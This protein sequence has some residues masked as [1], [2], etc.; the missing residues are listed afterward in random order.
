[1]I[2]PVKHQYVSGVNWAFMRWMDIPDTEDRRR[3][4]LRRFIVFKTPL[5]AWYIHWI[6]LP[7]NGRDPHNHPMN[8]ISFILRGSYVEK[9]F[10]TWGTAEK[11]G[12]AVYDRVRKRFSFA[13]TTVRD[14]H[15]ITRIDR[16]PVVTMIFTGKRQ[17]DWG[18][19]TEHEGYVPQE[20]YRAWIEAN[21][22]KG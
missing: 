6:Y 8:F 19:L 4:Y 14:F 3:V 16:T 13:R 17:Q 20:E 18:F 1:M 9:R 11:T 22:G 12:I 15:L 21:N 10:H 7:D 5:C 2:P